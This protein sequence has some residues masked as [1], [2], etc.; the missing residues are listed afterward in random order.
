MGLFYKDEETTENLTNQKE[1]LKEA[2]SVSG[3]STKR[4]HSFIEEK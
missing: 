2:T 4:E 3:H 1:K